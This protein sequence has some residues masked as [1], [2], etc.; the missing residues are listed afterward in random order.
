MVLGDAGFVNYDYFIIITISFRPS[1][2]GVTLPSK[3]RCLR[4]WDDSR[5]YYMPFYVGVCVKYRRNY[6]TSFMDDPFIF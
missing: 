1:M 6:V 5:R 4:E 3:L 2:N